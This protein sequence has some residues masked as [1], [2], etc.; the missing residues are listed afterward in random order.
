M[1][2]TRRSGDGG[3][4]RTGFTIEKPLQVVGQ[5][6]CGLVSFIQP[7]SHCFAYYK[8]QWLWNAAINFVW[9]DGISSDHLLDNVAAVFAVKDGLKRC[10]FVERCAETV[11]IRP[12]INTLTRRL[13]RTH[14]A[15]RAEDVA[16]ASSTDFHLPH[17]P[18]QNQRSIRDPI[19]RVADCSA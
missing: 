16:S 9:S 10:Q 14:V 6:L 7:P 17:A 12:S 19:C 11:H 4:A 18:I 13:L 5:F 15:Q 1:V 2:F 8:T 3:R